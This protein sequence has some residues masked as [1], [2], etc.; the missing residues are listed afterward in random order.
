MEKFEFGKVLHFTMQ[1]VLYGGGVCGDG[2]Y[3]ILFYDT[4]HGVYEVQVKELV[5]KVIIIFVTL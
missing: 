2:L 5:P 3:I 1:G 4:Q